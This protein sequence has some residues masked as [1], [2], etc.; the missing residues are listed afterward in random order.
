MRN[1]H[2]L[3]VLCPDFVRFG[4][5]LAMAAA[6]AQRQ[7]SR[8]TGLH[9]RWPVLAVG[10]AGLPDLAESLRSEA[11]QALLAA[12]RADDAFA[13]FVAGHGRVQANWRVLEGNPEIVLNYL[14]AC[15][16][17]LVLPSGQ[18]DQALA[19]G[20]VSEVIL[21]CQRP[22]LVVP[23]GCADPDRPPNGI[24]IAWNGSIEALRAVA[25]ALPLLGRAE[26]V[27]LLTGQSRRYSALTPD[28]PVL[29]L[30][31]W[32]AERGILAETRPLQ[33]RAGEEGEALLL[34]SQAAGCDLLV[35][36]A[37]G[38]T[39]LREWILGGATRHVLSHAR[40]PLLMAH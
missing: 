35:M 28:R 23:E 7:A 19:P 39:R 6:L 32:L 26:R 18:G 16:D 2:D 21:Q 29:D 11:E 27:V 38:H 1:Y 5:H 30:A 3:L 33:A 36:G 10:A 8:L 17:L 31:A 37:W 13:A 4:P 25:G 20:F 40:L 14:A 24:A 12:T 15:H 9:V 34:A 22:C